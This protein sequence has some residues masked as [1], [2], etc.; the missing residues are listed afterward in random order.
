MLAVL[1]VFVPLLIW[2]S[3]ALLP[4]SKRLPKCRIIIK[5]K[6]KKQ[7]SVVHKHSILWTYFS[8]THVEWWKKI[9]NWICGRFMNFSYCSVVE[10]GRLKVKYK[11][12]E[13]SFWLS[14]ISYTIFNIF[15]HV[16]LIFC[17]LFFFHF[18]SWSNEIIQ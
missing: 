5:L 18:I 16:Y 15:P 1:E 10:K 17:H 4:S 6:I 11:K 7:N 8:Q 9:H 3:L 14:F 13:W 12:N 2:L